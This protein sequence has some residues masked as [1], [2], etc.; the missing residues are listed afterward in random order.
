MPCEK[1]EAFRKAVEAAN[2]MEW[3]KSKE[4]AL[5][6][7]PEAGDLFIRSDTAPSRFIALD[8]FTARTF[9]SNQQL[10]AAKVVDS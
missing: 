2:A 10:Q 1:S 8:N 5:A 6:P 3:K 7:V 4:A 9:G